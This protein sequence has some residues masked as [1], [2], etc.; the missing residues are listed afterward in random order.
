M[1]DA[2]RRIAVLLVLGLIALVAPAAS[3]G[4]LGVAS[5]P[6]Q[7]TTGPGSDG[8][9][10]VAASTFD[11]TAAPGNTVHVFQ[12]TG[13]AAARAGGGRCGDSKRPTI[14]M[15]HGLGGTDPS[16]YVALIDHLVSVGNV[17]VY[18][19]YQVS[20]G[21][22]TTL[23]QAYRYVDAGVVEAARRLPRFDTTRIGWWGHSF[24]ASMVPF[25]ATQGGRR[26]WGADGFWVNNIAMTF[27]L[28]VGPGA[29]P[30]PAHA[31]VLTVG[32]EDD[33]LADN[34]IGD[35]VY[36]AFSVPAAQKRHLLVSSDPHGQPALV[37]EHNSPI[38]T[39]GPTYTPDAI[40]FLLWRDLDQLELCALGGGY[41]DASYSAAGA[42]SD[43]VSVVPAEQ[44]PHPGDAGPYPALL[45][46]C[47]GVYGQMLNQ[48]RLARC[49][50]THV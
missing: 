49:G 32:F 17:V 31:Q 22:Q 23:E 38:A 9:C 25:L 39:D 29:I 43:G 12:P 14:V 42:W 8:G 41:C 45:A 50:P 40:D 27:A 24:G 20:D 47:D 7:P 15:A 18:P 26:H 10:G 19:T 37:A 33:A 34:R 28:L 44:S 48:E 6:R 13:R 4:P 11:N 35:E 2:S 1:P 36:D 46:E 21:S 5:Q 16:S 3:A 30:L